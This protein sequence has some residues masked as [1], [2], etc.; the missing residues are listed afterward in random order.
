MTK[1]EW[2]D[3]AISGLRR[4]LPSDRVESAR[5][6]I[7]LKL[8]F[9]SAQLRRHPSFERHIHVFTLFAGE[10]LRIVVETTDPMIVWHVG[11]QPDPVTE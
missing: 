8:M 4:A 1:P 9:G 3:L 11:I 2:N 6:A 5:S 7:D 10:T